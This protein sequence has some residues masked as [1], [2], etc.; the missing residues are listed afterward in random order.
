MA[1]LITMRKGKY[2]NNDAVEN[3][4]RYVTRTRPME[5]RADELIAWGGWGD[6]HL[7]DTGADYRTV[8]PSAEDTS[9]RDTGLK[10]ISRSAQDDRRR[11]WQIRI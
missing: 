3:V 4:L 9:D 10:D 8:S 1:I 2:T 11:V 6:R 7:P 5:D